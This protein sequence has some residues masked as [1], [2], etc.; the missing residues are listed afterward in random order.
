MHSRKLFSLL[1]AHIMSK[2]FICTRSQLIFA[3][4]KKSVC[5]FKEFS[6]LFQFIAL[7]VR[8]IHV[9]LARVEVTEVDLGILAFDRFKIYELRAIW[10]F[11]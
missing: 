2:L 4:E 3:E 10:F 6:E 8:M 11:E 7:L 9:N 5:G 1:N